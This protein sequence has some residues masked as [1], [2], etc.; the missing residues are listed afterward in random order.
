MHCESSKVKQV[1]PQ[2][3]SPP[4]T[5]PWQQQHHHQTQSAHATGPPSPTSMSSGCSSPGYSPS[6]TLDL[7]GSSSSFSDRKA[8]AACYNYKGGPVHEWTKEQVGHWLMGIELERYIPVF[9]EHNVEGGALLTLDSKDFKTLGVCGDDK[10]RLKKRLKDL[11]ASIEKE[12]KDM[13]RERR[14]RE[15]AIRKAEK[16]AAKKK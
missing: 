1:V 3:L 7:S 15:K 10:N 9:K 5:V 13:E 12:R 4:G 6:R 14:E 11:K 16:K 2:S 8:A